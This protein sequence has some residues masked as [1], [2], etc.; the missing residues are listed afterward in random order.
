MRVLITGHCGQ[1]GRTLSSRLP[2][3]QGVDLPEVDITQQE[4]IDEAV[5]KAEPELIIHCAAMT[6]VDGAAR[7][8]ALAERINGL[9]TANVARAAS[10]S[11]AA[12]VYISTNEVFDGTKKEPYL[13]SDAPNPINAYGKSKLEGERN[14]ARATNDLYIVRTSWV[15]AP[16]GS[17]F[18]HRIQQ[19]ADERGRLQVVT[20]EVASPTFVDDLADAILRLVATH[21]FGVY[22]LTNAGYCS[23][24]DYAR[25]IL[26]MSGRSHI[27]VDPITL[28]QFPRPSTPPKF[29]PL[30]NVNAAAFGITLPRWEESLRAFLDGAEGRERSANVV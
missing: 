12:L 23:R 13:E 10:R 17:N 3:A 14:A 5:G 21:R 26:E 2:E 11:K 19:I 7:D 22:H 24:Y 29:S 4:S 20:D 8:P 15:A 27:P 9:G 25:K 30:A 6:N 16:G 28:A 1:L 18:I